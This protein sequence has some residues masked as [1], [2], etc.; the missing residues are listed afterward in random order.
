MKV[1]LQAQQVLASFVTGSAP[2][3]DTHTSTHQAPE[4]V[5][6]T[7]RLP[8]SSVRHGDGWGHGHLD[9][10]DRAHVT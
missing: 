10:R 2:S 7:R 1:T 9:L 8:L 5:S 3:T 6:L 4:A